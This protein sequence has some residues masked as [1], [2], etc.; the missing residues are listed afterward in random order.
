MMPAEIVKLPDTVANQ[1]AAGEV[2]ERPVAV[3]KELVEN[4]LDAGATTIEVQFEKGGK[5]LV[6]VLDN[7]SGMDDSNAVL[8]L[9]RHATSKIRQVEDILRISSF[10]FRGEALPSIASVSRF[11]LKT[12]TRD[13]QEGTEVLVSGG[14]EPVVKAC[15]M[16]PGT[17]VTVTH[18]FHNVPARRKFMKTDRTESAHIIQM[19]RLLAVAHPE[20]AFSLIEDG[21]E[22]FRSP[23][24]PDRIQRVR[25][26]F[27]KRRA[28]DLLPIN[29]E[30]NGMKVYGLVGAPGVG[31][32]T[33]SEM[34]TF[35]NKRPVDSR[36]LNYALIESY[37]RYLPRGRYPMAFLFIDLPEGEVDVNVHP[38]KRE[39]RFRA[40]PVVRNA[41]MA[42]LTE[43]LAGNSR[44][45]LPGAEAVEPLEPVA[46]TPV[47]R[48][49]IVPPPRAERKDFPEIHDKPFVPDPP[50]PAPAVPSQQSPDLRPATWRFC[51]ILRS[52]LGLF[53]STDG[54]IILN[55][56][57]ARERILFEEMEVSIKGGE[58]VR[59]EL[60]IPLMVELPPLDATLLGDQLEF[61]DSIGFEIEP[62]GRHLFRLRS[63]PVWINAEKAEAF[64]EELI[65]KIRDRGLRPEE[66]HPA[67]TL[68]AR[69]AAIREARGFTPEGDSG[70]RQLAAALLRCENPL[71]DAR[72]R[73]AFVEMRQGEI[74]RKLMLDRNQRGSE[75]L[76]TGH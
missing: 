57:A 55:A 69:L 10:G 37:H 61:F 66:R 27:G 28:E 44:Q 1:I 25:E 32:S 33:R 59:Q 65:G 15:G 19:C 68:V 54:L 31:R 3:V 14:G 21:H 71:L 63:L 12:R 18:L 7:G 48:P 35:I 50:A 76:D 52:R 29:F 72:G 46:P 8:A 51:G 58:I 75:G 17:E 45:S 73:P 36:L 42:G 13:L 62:F 30:A 40:E 53:E 34:I 5:S 38:T 39:V 2:V 49:V 23:V 22:V 9:Q 6:R 60:L 41:V 26:I 11:S 64:V 16:S 43:F 70:W 47:P 20:V 24:C 4:A 74:N 67:A 56:A